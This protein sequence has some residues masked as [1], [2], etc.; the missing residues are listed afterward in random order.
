MPAAVASNVAIRSAGANDLAV[1]GRLL[2]DGALPT[3]DLD[4]LR[5]ADF[6]IAEI[7]GVPLGTAGV[8]LYAPVGLLR[9]V[10]VARELR[11][12]G[13]GA[14]LVAAVE[15][16]A[17][18]RGVRDLYLLTTTAERFFGRRGYARLERTAAPAAIR[19]TTEFSALCP[20]TAV[21]MHRR[22]D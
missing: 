2:A 7:D 9:S 10:A 5:A 13:V 11:R 14:Q 20:A 18:D 19:G 4:T 22:L 15:R 3:G 1:I 17:R 21:L 6:V 8:E 16:R 12:R